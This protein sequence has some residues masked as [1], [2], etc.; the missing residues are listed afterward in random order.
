MMKFCDCQSYIYCGAW[1]ME[2]AACG[3]R[4][5]FSFRLNNFI[6]VINRYQRMAVWHQDTMPV[7]MT[8]YGI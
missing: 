3:V 1:V 5:V 7:G 2:R 8:A 6:Y 4:I